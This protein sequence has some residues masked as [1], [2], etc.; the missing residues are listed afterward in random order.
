V[1]RRS[2]ALILEFLTAV[3]LSGFIGEIS[4]MPRF[5]QRLTY[6]FPAR[7]CV[8]SLLSIFMAGD[9]I[10]LL[11]DER[12]SAAGVFRFVLSAQCRDNSQTIGMK[13]YEEAG[14]SAHY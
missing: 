8:Q 5:I 14:L 3:Q 13:C 7:Y 9:V 2:F 1:C 10:P 12:I 11:G 4:S 6:L